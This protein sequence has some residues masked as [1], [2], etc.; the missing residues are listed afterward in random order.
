MEHGRHVRLVVV[1]AQAV[2]LPGHASAAT[3]KHPFSSTPSRVSP[4]RVVDDITPAAPHACTHAATHR[5]TDARETPFSSVALLCYFEKIDPQSGTV[6]VVHAPITTCL[7]E[8][9][10]FFSSAAGKR[11][12]GT[13]R[14]QQPGRNIE[15]EGD[16]GVLRG[17]RNGS[18][19]RLGGGSW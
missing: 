14:S 19:R 3:N 6:P 18:E 7:H 2:V 16:N 15:V 5:H 11:Y 9:F 1:P 17:L 12:P 4:I 8:I 13:M 10:V